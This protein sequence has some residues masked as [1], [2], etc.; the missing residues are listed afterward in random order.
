MDRIIKE[1]G[2]IIVSQDKTRYKNTDSNI[3]KKWY[4]NEY[5]SMELLDITDEDG[6]INYKFKAEEFKDFDIRKFTTLEKLQ[7]AYSLFQYEMLFKNGYE[8]SFSDEN[9]YLDQS[10][11]VELL[12]VEDKDVYLE[13][14]ETQGM[15]LQ[16]KARILSM[17]SRYSFE[18]V[19]KSNFTLAFHSNFEKEV[20]N[21]ES[22]EDLKQVVI[23]YIEK[24]EKEQEENFVFVK[25][26]GFILYRAFTMVF[27]LLFL[28]VTGF[29]L[30]NHF[31]YTQPLELQNQLYTEFT[32]KNYSEVLKISKGE[33]LELDQKYIVGYSGIM[34]SSLDDAKKNVILSTYSKTAS[35]TTMEYWMNIGYG[36]YKQA[37]D[38]GK[39]LNNDEYVIYALRLE[40]NR[41]LNDDSMDGET[42][43][44]DLKSVQDQIKTY[45]E[46]LG[47]GVSSN[48]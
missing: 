26:R 8:A 18:E 17:F 15:M 16:L 40:E 10:K 7:C 47:L 13:N 5:K 4:P 46:K 1:N 38:K 36:D 23:K 12:F 39:S 34:T 21:T 43:E 41:L 35:E 3:L 30:Y 9:L 42:K 20:L 27:L 44:A 45:E 32:D 48:E 37:I 22:L 31:T 19:L 28:C 6:Y 24:Q 25:K 29:S 11:N 2:M 14:S 33:S